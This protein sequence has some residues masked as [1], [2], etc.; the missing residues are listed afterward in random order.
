ML[1]NH[2]NYIASE[3][4]AAYGPLFNPSLSAEAKEAQ[5][6]RVATKLDYVVKHVLPEGRKYI[7]GE[8]LDVASLYLYIVLSWSAYVG[9]DL[10]AYPTLTAFSKTV[11]AVPEVAQAHA[12]MNASA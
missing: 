12:E 5:K 3:V 9:V 10:S 4:H 8:T 7:M 6:A 11:A 2:L 1:I